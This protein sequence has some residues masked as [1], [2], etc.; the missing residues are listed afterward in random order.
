MQR[1]I[2]EL[3]KGLWREIP[4]FRVMLGLCPVLAVTKNAENGLGMGIAVLFVLVLSNAIIY[5]KLSVNS[6][7]LAASLTMP[8]LWFVMLA[9]F[10]GILSALTGEIPDI[11]AVPISVLGSLTLSARVFIS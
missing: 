2:Q 7:S 11:T 1:F 9:V 6:D 3:T 8:S 5:K 4:P 10:F